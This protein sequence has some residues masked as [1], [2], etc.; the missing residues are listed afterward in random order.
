[1]KN[2]QKFGVQEMNAQELIEIDGGRIPWRLFKKWG[3]KIIAWSGVYDA[4]DD[5][6]AGFAEGNCK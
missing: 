6:S 5:F 2:L 4:I 3:K 1:M